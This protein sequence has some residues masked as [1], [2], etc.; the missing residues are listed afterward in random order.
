MGTTPNLGFPYPGS[1]D[2][3]DVSADIQ[4]LAEAVDAQA[5]VYQGKKS[6][7]AAE[8]SRTANSYDYLGTPDR[9]T[10]IVLPADAL[11]IVGFQAQWKQVQAGEA[12]AAIFLGANQLKRQAGGSGP[13]VAE[14]NSPLATGS[15]VPLASCPEGLKSSN[16]NPGGG[17]SDVTT[18]QLVGQADTGD[19]FG[20]A[21][22]FAAAGTY[23]VGVK[24]K[25]TSGIG[26]VSVK[27]RKL[28]VWTIAFD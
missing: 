18:G 10:G 21:T 25:C 1:A 13:V 6:I 16:A 20:L 3:F 17:G 24:F 9:V 2:D 28:W 26:P 4:A 23:E 27:E 5:V 11:I 7:V 19:W 15:Y 14:S 22:I 8:Q 12:V